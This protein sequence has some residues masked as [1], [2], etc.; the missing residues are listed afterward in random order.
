MEKT[1]GSTSG[2]IKGLKYGSYMGVFDKREKR[3]EKIELRLFALRNIASNALNI[4]I[5]HEY[6]DVR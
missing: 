1:T 5:M 3:K 6:D 4:F 2:K